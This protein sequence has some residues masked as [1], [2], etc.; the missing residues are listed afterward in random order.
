MFKLSKKSELRLLKVN[1]ALIEIVEKALTITNV[2]FGIPEHGGFRTAS[3]QNKLFKD[4]KSRADGHDKQSYHQTGDAIDFYAYIDNK[5]SWRHDHLAMVACALM[6]SASV[7]GYGVEWGGL[8][9]SN[10]LTNG[11]PYGWDMGHI[12]LVD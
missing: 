6:Q 7:L 5:A 4:G 9:R 2:D 1:P 11:I 12:Q 3:D 8:W 10:K